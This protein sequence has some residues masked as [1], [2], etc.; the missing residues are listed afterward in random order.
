MSKTYILLP[1][2]HNQPLRDLQAL[3]SE[4]DCSV[5]IVGGPEEASA[6]KN[7]LAGCDGLI[8]LVGLPMKELVEI[9]SPILL[10]RSVG[11]KVIG[12]WIPGAKSD[13]VPQVLET[14]GAA[15][16]PWDVEEICD[17]I[18]GDKSN[19]VTA[20]GETRGAPKTKRHKC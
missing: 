6:I 4:C 12:L 13:A 2:G 10:A 19:W 1:L 20:D 14:Y 9:E 15:L 5:Q 17:A 3:A 18:C 7:S 11:K 16:V 8:V